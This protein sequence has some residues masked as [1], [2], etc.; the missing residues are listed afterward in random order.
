MGGA[1][2]EEGISCPSLYPCD[3][4]EECERG[5]CAWQLLM[6]VFAGW[7]VESAVLTQLLLQGIRVI[8][9]WT[10]HG[11]IWAREGRGDPCSPARR[12]VGKG[13]GGGKRGGAGA[14]VAAG[15]IH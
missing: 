2:G 10:L 6:A 7:V 15:K 5:R 1:K 13:R 8:T 11:E 9:S 12:D 4:Q 14:A 3:M